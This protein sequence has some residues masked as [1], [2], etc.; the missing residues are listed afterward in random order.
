MAD[1]ANIENGLPPKLDL[2]KKIITPVNVKPAFNP[3]A[4]GQPVPAKP[5]PPAPAPLSGDTAEA[6][7]DAF[8]KGT[9]RITLPEA[10]AP[11]ARPSLPTLSKPEPADQSGLPAVADGT[12]LPQNAVDSAARTPGPRPL[13]RPVMVPKTIKLKKPVP[14]GI[15]R[16]EPDAAA[17]PGSKRAT[18]K[19]SLPSDSDALEAATPTGTHPL[20]IPQTQ[21]TPLAAPED[22]AGE[23]GN[24]VAPVLAEPPPPQPAPDPKR[25]TSR[26]S[27]ESV[28][29]SE[30]ESGP[31]TIKLKRPGTNTIK[32]QGLESADAADS[33]HKTAAIDLPAESTD[34][35]SPETQKKTIKVKRPSMR[36]SMREPG[37]SGSSGSAG[38]G[39]SPSMMFT[40]PTQA[41]AASDS[42]H[43][44]FIVSACAATLITC[45]LV[46]VLCAQVLGPNISLTALSYGVPDAELPWPGRIT[47]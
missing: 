9:M 7:S 6:S 44:T 23:S 22:S 38:S 47:R 15:K 46:Y 40:P 4:S 29:G 39:G 16:N 41:L 19:I 18:S 31:K 14:L 27:L 25:Q 45:V 21:P 13:V 30:G 28:L 43:W 37:P 12:D 24:D 36:P 1:T 17:L 8:A 10:P 11:A 20:R 3:P 32:V 26:I 2:R 34:N 33:R 42:A 35:E 5:L